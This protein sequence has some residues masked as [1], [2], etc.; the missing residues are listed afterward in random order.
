MELNKESRDLDTISAI[1]Q[2]KRD[3]SKL[4][5]TRIEYHTEARASCQKEIRQLKDLATQI[6]NGKYT[7]ST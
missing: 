5:S 1:I 4:H 2:I 7:K 3:E 6:K